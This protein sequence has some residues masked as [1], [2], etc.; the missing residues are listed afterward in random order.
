MM[1]ECEWP[2]LTILDVAKASKVVEG[3]GSRN[4]LVPLIPDP[5]V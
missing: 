2:A 3:A 5:D 1:I 4:V